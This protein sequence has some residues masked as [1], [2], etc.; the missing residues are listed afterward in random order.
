MIQTAGT[1]KCVGG[2]VLV[3]P[4]WAHSCRCKCLCALIVTNEVKRSC[5]RSTGREKDAW[6]TS[7]EPMDKNRIDGAAERREGSCMAPVLSGAH[8]MAVRR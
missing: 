2:F 7:G 3:R 6:G 8:F 4:V 1:R 5:M